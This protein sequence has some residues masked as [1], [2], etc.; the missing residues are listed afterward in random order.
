[1]R[2]FSLPGGKMFN[3]HPMSDGTGKDASPASLRPRG[4]EDLRFLQ[5]VRL[6]P[7]RRNAIDDVVDADK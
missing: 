3:R 2:R 1:M 5:V 4:V 6:N 7:F